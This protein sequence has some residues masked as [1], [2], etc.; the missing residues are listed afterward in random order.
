MEDTKKNVKEE[1]V[2]VMTFTQ[3]DME[4]K[5]QM[6]IKFT[7]GSAYDAVCN[8]YHIVKSYIEATDKKIE[9]KENED[10]MKAIIKKQDKEV[11]E[12]IKA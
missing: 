2:R 10:R 11:K 3:D 8:F 7:S 9:D 1:L 5:F 4:F 6:P 12:E